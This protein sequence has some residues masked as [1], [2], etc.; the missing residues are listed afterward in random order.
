M[1]RLKT[2]ESIEDLI[3]LSQ[4]HLDNPPTTTH[5]YDQTF[6][7]VLIKAITTLQSQTESGLKPL[8]HFDFYKVKAMISQLKAIATQRRKLCLAEIRKKKSLE[9]HFK[10]LQDEN[11]HVANEEEKL[12]EENEVTQRR[13]EQ[14]RRI[15]ELELKETEEVKR[16][17]SRQR[18]RERILQKMKE[19][20]KMAAE[21]EKLRA[22]KKLV[23]YKEPTLTAIMK[24]QSAKSKMTS[25]NTL[26]SKVAPDN[27]L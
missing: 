15:T 7:Q 2:D 3:D 10:Q 1:K 12:K 19:E 4:D 11:Q 25:Q 8:S 14:F 5:P 27:P 26:S 22:P 18:S 16:E 23:T 9:V 24:D 13:L 21:K 6:E 17:M 20:E